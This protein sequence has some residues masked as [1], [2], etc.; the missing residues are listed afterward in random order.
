MNFVQN[1]PKGTLLYGCEI[2]DTGGNTYF[3]NM[4]AAYDALSDDMQNFLGDLQAHHESEH[5]HSRGYVSRSGKLRDGENT[6]P[7]AL[8]PIVRTH[9]VTGRK[10]IFVNSGFTTRFFTGE[11]YVTC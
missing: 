11:V 3:A 1:P 9:P 5:V 6:Y 7:A 4:Y 8:H 2:P 10:G